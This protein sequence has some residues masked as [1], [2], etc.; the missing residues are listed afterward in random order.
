MPTV[1][2]H[3]TGSHK[4]CTR[5]ISAVKKMAAKA[6]KTAKAQKSDADLRYLFGKVDIII[7]NSSDITNI[8][9]LVDSIEAWESLKSAHQ[10]LEAKGY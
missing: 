8:G 4:A 3:G 10:Y 7:K 2:E 9:V 1:C 6:T 5:C